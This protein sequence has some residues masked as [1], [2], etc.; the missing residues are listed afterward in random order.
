MKHTAQNI[1]TN[2]PHFNTNFFVLQFHAQLNNVKCH[3]LD[4]SSILTQKNLHLSWNEQYDLL[5]PTG[6]HTR[7]I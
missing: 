3:P 6:S 7:L 2:F 5:E 1:A 4:I